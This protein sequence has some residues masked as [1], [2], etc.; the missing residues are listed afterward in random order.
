MVMEP[1]AFRAN[2]QTR[3]TNSYQS[4][5]PDNLNPVQEAAKSE[6]RG[7]RDTLAE[8]GVIMTTTLGKHDCPDDV[9]CNNWV[10]THLNDDGKR[11][12]VLYPMLADNRRT[13]RRPE[14]IEWLGRSYETALDLSQYENTNKYLESTGSLAMDR[15]NK[16]AFCALSSR[17]DQELAEKFC[18]NMGYEL[19]R[20]QTENH[21]GKPVYHTDVMMFIGTGYIGICLEC[22]LPEDRKRILSEVEKYHTVIELSM[23]QLRQF[24]GNALEIRGGSGQTFLAMSNAAEQSLTPTQKQNIRKHVTDILSAPIPTIE[25]YGGGSVR[26]M[27]LELH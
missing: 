7:L 18:E 11:S 27:L 2:E 8:A 22:I 20:F 25:K 21:E 4:D 19:H 14:L 5:N 6:F 13:E 10:S 16:R 26:C 12:M 17:S 3:S 23:E 15:V 1:V 24:A 9:F